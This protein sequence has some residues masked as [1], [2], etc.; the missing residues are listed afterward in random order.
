MN[1]ARNVQEDKK[2]TQHR[3]RMFE[4]A[5]IER[6]FFETFRYRPPIVQW[7]IDEG[8]LEQQTS[9]ERKLDQLYKS[10]AKEATP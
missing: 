8:R 7:L 4:H 3:S 6:L 9:F 10:I 5:Q 1:R 2:T